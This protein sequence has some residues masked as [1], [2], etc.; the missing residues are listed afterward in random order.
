[1]N[2]RCKQL[3][4]L[5]EYNPTDRHWPDYIEKFGFT[6]SDIPDLLSILSDPALHNVGINSKEV[7]A[8]LHAWRIL[9]QLHAEDA[10][11][12]LIQLFDFLKDDDWA[13]SEVPDVLGMIGQP[14]INPLQDYFLS[15]DPVEDARIMA[16]D[17]LAKIAEQT[18]KEQ[19]FNIFKTY[20]NNPDSS[21]KSL[22]GLLI[23]HLMDLEASSLIEPISQ[24]FKRD[25]VDITICG[26]LE[27]VEIALGLRLKRDTP[28]PDYYSMNGSDFGDD[29]AFDNEAD[30]PGDTD[31]TYAYDVIE[32]LLDKYGHDESIL[33][34]SELDGYFASLA[35]APSLIMPSKWMALIWGG[36]HLTPE[37]ESHE[38]AKLFFKLIMA[39]YNETMNSFSS[40]N[41]NPLFLERQIAEKTYMIVDEWCEGFLRALPLWP[42]SKYQHDQA[43]LDFMTAISPFTSDQGF[44]IIQNLSYSEI[45]QYQKKITPAVNTL[46]RHY[47]RQRQQE[48]QPIIR[49]APKVGRNDPCP[50]GSGKKF[51]KC[52]LH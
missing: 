8:P 21:L 10:V 22:N 2:K 12:P 30:E 17:G 24:L 33:D 7:W 42:I 39:Y 41:Y 9:G 35:C 15:S 6:K 32:M 36:E 34:L 37:W 44:Q 47:A 46:Y 52:C 18:Q 50:C 13:F 20:M 51:K 26:D 49:G 16:M 19:I 23:A 11:E 14:A 43:L 29:D 1:M 4:T 45:E 40:G 38:E 5:G 3:L 25:C 31:N 28:K 48:G 27:E